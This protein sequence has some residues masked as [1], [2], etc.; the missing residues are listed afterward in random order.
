M[1]LED[2]INSN[3]KLFLSEDAPRKQYYSR[4]WEEKEEIRH[5]GQRKLL[6]VEIWFLM[7]YGHLSKNVIYAGAAPGMHI[8]YLSKLFQQHKFYLYDPNEFKV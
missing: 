6:L 4:A 5:W 8:E 7:N 1:S 2:E 3:I